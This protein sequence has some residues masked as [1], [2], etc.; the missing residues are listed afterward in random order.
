MA[1]TWER[2]YVIGAISTDSLGFS[3]RE[4][5]YVRKAS[6]DSVL[7]MYRLEWNVRANRGPLQVH[8]SPNSPFISIPRFV[9]FALEN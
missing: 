8:L 6:G 5:T 9:S 4:T 2:A 1:L 3:K 7:Y